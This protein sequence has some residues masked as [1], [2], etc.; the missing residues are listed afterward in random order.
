MPGDD[1]DKL[2][3]GRGARDSPQS[4]RTI[5]QVGMFFESFDTGNIPSIHLKKTALHR[6]KE[7]TIVEVAIQTQ[8]GEMCIFS[9]LDSV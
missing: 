9:L 2:S 1:L 3:E 8:H 6:Y 7:T 5:R 4:I